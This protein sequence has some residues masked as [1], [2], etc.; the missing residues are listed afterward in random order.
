MCERCSAGVLRFAFATF[1]FFGV[2]WSDCL[3]DTE[4]V[5]LFAR[6]TSPELVHTPPISNW[7]RRP[8]ACCI[9]S[10][11]CHNTHSTQPRPA[12]KRQQAKSPTTSGVYRVLCVCVSPLL[13]V[14]N[15]KESGRPTCLV[16]VSTTRLDSTRPKRCPR[17]TLLHFCFYTRHKL[18]RSCL[19]LIIQVY[20]HQYS[21]V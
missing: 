14:F 15:G 8:R 16:C 19:L 4:S 3:C 12:K 21:T 9:L 13:A 2:L 5:Y 7:S 1:T 6:D 20:H 18:C 17:L 11:A 10:N